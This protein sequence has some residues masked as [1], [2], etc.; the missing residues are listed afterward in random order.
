MQLIIFGHSQNITDTISIVGPL[1]QAI[2]LCMVPC[3]VEVLKFD[4]WWRK[5]N[6]FANAKLGFFNHSGST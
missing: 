6:N 3:C 5:I 2:S 1:G 4:P